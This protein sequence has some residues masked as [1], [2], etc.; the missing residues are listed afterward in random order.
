MIEVGENGVTE[1]AET[2]EEVEE[3]PEISIHVITGAIRYSTMKVEGMV[4]GITHNFLDATMTT[5]FGCQREEIAPLNVLVGNGNEM[6]CNQTCREFVWSMQGH[7][8]E[9]DVLIIHSR[10]IT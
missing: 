1:P 4:E 3:A 10:V 6:K 7:L 8:F 5:K 2:E 9:T